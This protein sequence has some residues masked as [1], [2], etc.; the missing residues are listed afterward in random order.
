MVAG[1]PRLLQAMV[2]VVSSSG[3]L[4]PALAAMEMSQMATQV[5]GLWVRILW[6]V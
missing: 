4:N 5:G 3:W 2:D 1:A 6:L